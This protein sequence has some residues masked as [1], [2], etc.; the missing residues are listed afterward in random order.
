MKSRNAWFW[1]FTA[2]TVLLVLLA[3]ERLF[4]RPP[5]GPDLL[6]PGLN[7]AAVDSF[8]VLPAQADEIQVVRRGEAWRLVRP[9]E[10]P[11]QTRSIEALLDALEHLVPVTWI[12]GTELRQRPQDAA[13][14]GLT[15][16]HSSLIL[17]CGEGHRQ[18][19]IGSLTPP[20][21]QVFV[22]VVG[23]QGI[24]VLDAEV[25]KWIPDKANAWRDTAMF[26]LGAD[27]F[28]S[29]QV[30]VGERV[31]E[32]KRDSAG[33]AWQIV[34]PMQ[35]RADAVRLQK[36]IQSLRNLGVREFVSDDP[37]ADRVAW[38]L[39]PPQLE[40]VFAQGTNV[41]QKL[42]F[43]DPVPGL[44]NAVYAVALGPSAVVVVASECLQ[45]WQATPNEFRDRQLLRLPRELTA[46]EVRNGETFSLVNITNGTWR[47]EPMGVPADT[48][49]V[50]RFLQGIEE[51]RVTRFVKDVVA[52]PDLPQD[53]LTPPAFQVV[54]RFPSTEAASSNSTVGLE[55]GAQT[56]QGVFVRR[57]DETAVYAVEASAL[58]RI[59]AAGGHFRQLDLWNFSP[60]QV[61]SMGVQKGGV[62]WRLI[63]NG[64][65]QWSLAAGS[66]GIINA[67][68]VEEA[69]QRLGQLKA[70]VWTDWNP[71]ALAR[72]GVGE[73]SVTLSVELKDGTR[74]T[75][76]FG[77]PAP[78]GHVYAAVT[79]EGQ[80]WVFE[81]PGDTF[82]L[83][84]AF[85]IKPS[86]LR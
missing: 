64:T 86:N 11:A 26:D 58:A 49:T 37:R 62:V 31:M 7:A 21:D 1:S 10:Y 83:V 38:G 48:V 47:I 24:C 3:Y 67:F 61:A 17:S 19:L 43:G 51:L 23:A 35:A 60:E 52:E 25:L 30:T 76:R 79:L 65:N 6:L 36:L 28:D 56:D 45:E 18:L 77:L 53:G 70:V 41:L 29:V 12:S 84:E 8:R 33:P 4:Y 15:P 78:S 54:F 68:A 46:V 72:Y 9:L 42:Q 63:H 80:S 57:I 39:Q 71:E 50:Q 5:A 73:D 22:Q 44:S 59:P 34:R 75:V 66:Q 2:A 27:S 20:G 81:F 40:M 55:F 74:K 69:A 32:L 85:L 13:A 16:P 14:Y 82:E